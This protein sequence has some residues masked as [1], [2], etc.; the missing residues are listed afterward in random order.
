MIS[1]ELGTSANPIVIE[2]GLAPLG[3]AFNPIVIDEDWRRNEPEQFG[4]DANTETMATPE[5]WESLTA[6]EFAVP[7]KDD[8]AIDSL[9][10]C[11]PNRSLVC[12]DREGSRVFERSTTDHF[13]LEKESKI[14]EYLSDMPQEFPSSQAARRENVASNYKSKLGWQRF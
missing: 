6:G 13:Q 5:F 9:P 12:E 2:D 8:T 11:V 3:S 1:P 4:S 7:V 14:N 10:V